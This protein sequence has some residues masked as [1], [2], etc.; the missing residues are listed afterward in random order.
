MEDKKTEVHQSESIHLDERGFWDKLKKIAKSAGCQLLCLALKLY[1]A[2]RKPSTP[3]WA[4][5]TI[6]IALA[7]FILPIDAIP[8]AVPGLG[9]TDDFGVMLTA[10]KAVGKSIDDDVKTTAAA[11]LRTWLGEDCVC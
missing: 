1:Y 3:L 10:L 7:Y 9:Y 2:Y 11:K 8:D 4:K 5:T 6:A